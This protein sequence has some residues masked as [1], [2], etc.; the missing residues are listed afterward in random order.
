MMR[1]KLLT[2]AKRYLDTLD[3]ETVRQIYEALRK[4]TKEPPIGDVK[5]LQG[6][7]TLYRLRLGSLRIIFEIKGNHILVEKIAPRG[8][9]CK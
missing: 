1:F 9:A 4:I 5:K 3:K 7:E 6:Y 8:Q 2:D